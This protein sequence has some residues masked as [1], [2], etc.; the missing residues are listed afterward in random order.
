MKIKVH[1][2]A[3]PDL[4]AI[5]GKQI[6]KKIAQ[7]KLANSANITK[8]AKQFWSAV[9]AEII[10]TFRANLSLCRFPEGVR[11]VAMSG[12]VGVVFWP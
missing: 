6:W 4:F 10:G 5:Y 1:L 9:L 11:Q 12:G 2:P 7:T 8:F 3:L